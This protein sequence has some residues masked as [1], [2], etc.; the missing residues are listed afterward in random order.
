M[1][2]KNQHEA[3]SPQTDKP[4]ATGKTP[5]DKAP[6][7]DQQNQATIEELGEEGLGIAPKE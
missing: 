4:G 3:E 6:V 7:N 2:S 1:P 5:A